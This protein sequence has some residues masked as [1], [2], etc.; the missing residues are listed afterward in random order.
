MI[1]WSSLPFIRRIKAKSLVI[2]GD[3][4]HIVPVINGSILKY[5]LP[6]AR[7]KIIKGAGHLFM[8]TRRAETIEIIRD[9]FGEPEVDMPYVEPVILPSV[10]ESF[11]HK[12]EFQMA[13]S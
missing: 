13:A 11:N 8:I 9:F 4:D 12:G 5:F 2:M 1:G 7:L 3:N 10:L 6:N